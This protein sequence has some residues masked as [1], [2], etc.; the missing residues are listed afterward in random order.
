[1]MQT[2]SYYQPSLAAKK[3]A[4]MGDATRAS[5][6][7]LLAGAFATPC[8]TAAHN[9]MQIVPPLSRFQLALDVLMPVLDAPVEVSLLLFVHGGDNADLTARVWSRS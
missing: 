9:F 8:S 1:M 3:T 6:H 5:V 2:V 4:T 7:H